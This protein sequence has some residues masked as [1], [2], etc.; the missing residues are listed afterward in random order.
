MGWER[1]LDLSLLKKQVELEIKN[2]SKW[3]GPNCQTFL[4]EVYRQRRI[5]NDATAES[6]QNDYDSCHIFR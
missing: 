4:P 1:K 6:L 2:H 3:C 5:M